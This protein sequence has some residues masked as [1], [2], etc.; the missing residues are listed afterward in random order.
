MTRK[1]KFSNWR[2]DLSDLSEY[3]GGG[4]YGYGTDTPDLKKASPRTQAQSEKEITEKKVKNKVII[5]PAMSEAFEKF[6]G[7]VLEVVELSEKEVDVKDT[8]RTVDA[9]RAYD[10][11]K[12]AS[13]DATDDSEEGRKGKGKK[14][15]A[16]AKKERGE[17]DKDDPNWK[18]RK[19]HTGMHGEALD[20]KKADMGDVVDDFYKSDAPQFKGKS[21]KK[22]REMAI[23]AKLNTEAM[24]VVDQ[25]KAS[26]KYWKENPR[27]D[28]KAGD[29]VKRNERD[30]RANAVRQPKDTR[31]SQQRMND[32]VGKSRAGE[33]D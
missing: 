3:Y 13:R 31:T 8:R 6:G 2:D 29:G 15:R 20:M 4:S 5:N 11:S 30:A 23:A 18:K 14:E 32:A 7:I 17:I 21:K 10:K 26:A 27:K 12:D 33:S 9:I 16:Y 19:Y 28:Y 22:R 25:M 24:S 1:N